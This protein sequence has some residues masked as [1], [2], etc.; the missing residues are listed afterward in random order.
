MQPGAKIGKQ[1]RRRSGRDDEK[2][3]ARHHFENRLS[4]LAEVCLNKSRTR[5]NVDLTQRSGAEKTTRSGEGA[6]APQQQGGAT[7]SE[8]TERA[9]KEAEL[10][11]API[12]FGRRVPGALKQALRKTRRQLSC[13]R[14]PAAS[15]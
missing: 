4:I 5:V 11:R 7:T 1:S 2:N 6:N 10:R 12:S 8:T 13:P 9:W 15:G 3:V 14:S